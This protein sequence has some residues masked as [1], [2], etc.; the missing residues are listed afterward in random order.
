MIRGIDESHESLLSGRQPYFSNMALDAPVSPRQV[1]QDDQGRRPSIHNLPPRASGAF[2]RPPQPSHINVSPRRYGSIGGASGIPSPS[3]HRPSITAPPPPQPQHP[4]AT[5]YE[6]GANLVRRHTSADI[7]TMPGW[8]PQNQQQQQ[9]QSGM[10]SPYQSGQSSGHWPS[11]PNHPPSQGDNE[12]R[13]QLASYELGR[14][15]RPTAANINPFENGGRGHTPPLQHGDA[16]PPSSL[17][18]EAN[19]WSFGAQNDR[20]SRETIK[21]FP[22]LLDSAPQTRRSSMASNVHSLLNPKETQERDEEAE[23]GVPEERKRKRIG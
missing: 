13:A 18:P 9:Q 23:N 4:L 22:R 21:A 20:S 17:G 1:P 6:P 16:L 10:G 12:V 14:P 19:H 11:S 2:F 8:P 5:A 15:R 3:Y 7:R